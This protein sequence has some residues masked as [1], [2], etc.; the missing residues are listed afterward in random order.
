MEVVT[1]AKYF[2]VVKV[3]LVTL[4]TLLLWMV[5]MAS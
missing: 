1:V 5:R 3:M 4:L 2:L